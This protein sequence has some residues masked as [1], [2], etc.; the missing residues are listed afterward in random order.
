MIETQLIELATN[1][2][3]GKEISIDSS[4]FISGMLDS[5]SMLTFLSLVEETYKVDILDDGFDIKDFDTIGL[6]GK[7]IRQSAGTVRAE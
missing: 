1:V 4:L 3:G 6:I 5:M 7:Y 2:S